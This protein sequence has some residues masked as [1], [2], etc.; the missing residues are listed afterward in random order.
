[1]MSVIR[2]SA[3][4]YRRK[5]IEHRLIERV[6]WEAAAEDLSVHSAEPAY[7]EEREAGGERE[8]REFPVLG[9]TV[10]NPKQVLILLLKSYNML[11]DEF[12]LRAAPLLGIGGEELLHLVD[13]LRSMRIEQDSHIRNFRER[14]YCQ[15]YRCKTFMRRYH[16]AP[17]GSNRKALLQRR[18]ERAEKRL[19]NMKDYYKTLKTGASNRQIAKLLGVP[20]GTVDSNLSAIKRNERDGD[21]EAPAPVRR[22]RPRR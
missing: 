13:E 17:E 9:E 10:S 2:Y 1:M 7:L 21:G 11:S 20:K 15:Y 6:Y 22:R 14:I 4:D 16:A 12:V 19:K 18:L 8:A 3:R 5:E